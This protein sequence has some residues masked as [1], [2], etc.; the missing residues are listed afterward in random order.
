MGF[1]TELVEIESAGDKIQK[2][3]YEV[4]QVQV[5]FF[6]KALED[7]LLCG[8]IDC[9]VHSL[10][11]LPTDLPKELLLGAVLKRSVAN[12]GLVIDRRAFDEQSPIP[13]RNGA[14]V[15]TSSLRRE[16]LLL[17]ER[18]DL[19][20]FPLRGNIQTRLEKVKGGT[21]DA[22]MLAEA[23]LTRL[24]QLSQSKLLWKQLPIEK[25]VPA[26][27]QGA[28][29]VEIKNDLSKTIRN[30]LA[31]IHDMTT[32][33]ETSL[34]RKILKELGGGCSLPLGVHCTITNTEIRAH[35]FLGTYESGI[36]P[37]RRW[38]RFRRVEAFDKTEANV[39]K[40]ILD[41]LSS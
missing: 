24:N 4:T 6:T 17:S 13:L 3:L 11:D 32:F 29:A 41:Q 35:G 27:G 2:P 39:L 19:K 14:T 34:E 33:R 16:A 28:I 20:I 9:A 38:T 18:P 26:P 5:G 8:T 1:R 22:A 36:S 25:F 30:A 37:L 10:K 40:K 31:K 7:A 12:D 21:L 15:G 23:G